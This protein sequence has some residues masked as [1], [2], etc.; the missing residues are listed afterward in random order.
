[1]F[2]ESAYLLLSCQERGFYQKNIPNT[3][4]NTEPNLAIFRNLKTSSWTAFYRVLIGTVMF[5]P[6]IPKEKKDVQRNY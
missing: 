6:A 3:N 1:M 4:Q 2:Q 5:F